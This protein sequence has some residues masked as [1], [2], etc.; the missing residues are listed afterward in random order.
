[1][2]ALNWILLMTILTISHSDMQGSQP[3]FLP[4]SIYF[5]PW[6]FWL[7]WTLPEATGLSQRSSQN[8]HSWKSHRWDDVYVN[9]WISLSFRV[10]AEMP[11]KRTCHMSCYLVLNP[12]L[13]L[14]VSETLV[15]FFFLWVKV[16]T[17]LANKMLIWYDDR[18]TLSICQLRECNI[19]SWTLKLILL[20]TNNI[21]VYV[22]E[23]VW[24]L[25]GVDFIYKNYWTI[26][27]HGPLVVTWESS[28]ILTT[29]ILKK[30]NFPKMNTGGHKA[31]LLYDTFSSMNHTEKH[32]EVS[33]WLPMVEFRGFNTNFLFQILVTV[34]NHVLVPVSHETVSF[35]CILSSVLC[36]LAWAV[37]NWGQL[38]RKT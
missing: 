29:A 7:S 5:L 27:I 13:N 20:I 31:I 23:C 8:T 38:Q 1:M 3:Q 28:L 35:F 4:L 19:H 37:V 2:L 21:C 14:F 33:A 24:I 22:K 32:L 10:R 12:D 16:F 11:R 6:T 34:S 15:F 36:L 25:C 17:Q 30:W 9:I 26:W 18:Y